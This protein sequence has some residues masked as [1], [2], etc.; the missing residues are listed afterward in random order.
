MVPA[1]HVVVPA[2]LSVSPPWI[3]T[4]PV[5]FVAPLAFK[6]PAPAKSP[7]LQLNGPANVSVPAPVNAPPNRSRRPAN[8]VVDTVTVPEPICAVSPG[9]GDTLG[10]HADGVVQSE[11]PPSQMMVADLAVTENKEAAMPI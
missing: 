8:T 5:M 7:A 2:R 1:L 4:V 9:P 11:A 10:L 3:E 6:I